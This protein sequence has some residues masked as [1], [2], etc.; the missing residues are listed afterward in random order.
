MVNLDDVDFMIAR[1]RARDCIKQLTKKLPFGQVTEYFNARRRKGKAD[2]RGCVHYSVFCNDLAMDAKDTSKYSA[3]L[4]ALVDVITSGT[5]MTLPGFRSFPLPHTPPALP[6]VF[7]PHFVYSFSCYLQHCVQPHL[8]A[9][10]AG[11]PPRQWLFH[12]LF[13]NVFCRRDSGKSS[14][15]F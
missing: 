4:Q 6:P 9:K 1:K 15:S 5:L 8:P 10:C 14:R 13:Q 12:F 7:S 2:E 11:F 3:P